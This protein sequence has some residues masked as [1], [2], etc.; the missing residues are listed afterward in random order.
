VSGEGLE[1]SS[2]DALVYGIGNWHFYNGDRERAREVFEQILEGGGWA[3][4]GYLAAEADY[5]RY[6]T[7]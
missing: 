4:F 2:N 1:G 5:H 3:S 7:R 6:F